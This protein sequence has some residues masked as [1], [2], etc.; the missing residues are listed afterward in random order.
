A[1]EFLGKRVEKPGGV[2]KPGK[3]RAGALK[4]GA[5]SLGDLY[6]LW[7]LERVGVIYSLSTI[8]GKD[9]YAWGAGLLV[10]AQ[11]DDGSWLGGQ[12]QVVDTCFALLFLRRVNVA[13]DL[14][15]QLQQMGRIRDPGQ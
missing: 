1:L 13:K 2:K 3:G 7:S 15:R 10:P 11:A 14:T 4:I 9:W 12:G 8:G 6:W 5:D